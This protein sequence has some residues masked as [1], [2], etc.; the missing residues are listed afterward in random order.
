MTENRPN[1][2]SLLGLNPNDPWDQD[3]FNRVIKEKQVKW[4]QVRMGMGKDAVA[5]N[6][7]IELI[8]EMKRV[9]N[10]PKLRAQEARSGQMNAREQAEMQEARLIEFGQRLRIL[11]VKGY[12]H[13]AEFTSLISDFKDVLTED[14]ITQRLEVE[15][16]SPHDDMQTALRERALDPTILANILADI[17]EKLTLLNLSSLY[18]LLGLP[19][20]AS[21]DEL[22]RAAERVHDDYS[23]RQPKTVEVDA[24][25]SLAGHAK[26]IFSSE[27][28]R[29]YYDE[30]LQQRLKTKT[31]AQNGLS[32]QWQA[33]QI[34]TAPL[35]QMGDISQVQ[36]RIMSNA[37]R[38]TWKWPDD[39][40]EALVF[41]SNREWPQPQQG[42][43]N[44]FR[45]TKAEYE[46]GGYYALDAV[47]NQDYY[48][49]VVAVLRSGGKQV[50]TAGARAQGFF[51]QHMTIGYEVKNP[52]LGRKQRTLHLYAP[53]SCRVPTLV[54]VSKSNGQPFS[55]AE[56]K[57]LH[58]EV[59]PVEIPLEKVIQLP[60]TPFPPETY[61]RLFLED[62]NYYDF[63]TIHHPEERKLRLDR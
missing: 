29:R 39:C 50:M 19:A 18:Q 22:Y 5:A 3:L 38:L 25:T 16:L 60:T 63:V 13:D 41:Y 35:K 51:W 37:L 58:R 48:L 52:R 46:A 45:V 2:Y 27:K 6:R 59:G 49:A 9:M 33:E 14:E 11:Q 62:D 31:I 20:T 21:C 61:A 24:G 23:R 10:D 34:Q 7:N 55:K 1:F 44:R 43:G 17:D 4:N 47:V 42:N 36:V 15:V 57:P 8:R 30:H 32:A 40:Y 53:Q 26:N 28:K 56:G 54:L 12:L